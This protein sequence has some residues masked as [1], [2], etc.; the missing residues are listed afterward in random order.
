MK[1]FA[2]IITAFSIVISFF[3]GLMPWNAVYYFDS[4]NGSDSNSGKSLEDAFQ[5]LDKLNSMKLKKGNTVY[6]ACGSTYRGQLVCQK[7]VTY[8]ACGEGEMPTFLGSADAAD[9][10]KWIKTEIPNVWMF[11]EEFTDDVGNI[12]FNSG[13]AVGLKQ[14]TGIFGFKGTVGELTDDLSF[15]HNTDDK[16]VYLSHQ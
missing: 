6:I 14:V 12:I 13:E 16:K 7:G 1:I 10:A 9:S 5:S 2:S 15:W 8:A 11:D 3:A 4:V